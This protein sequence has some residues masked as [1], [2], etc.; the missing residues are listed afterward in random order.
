[1]TV[2]I[3]KTSLSIPEFLR[4]ARIADDKTLCSF[5]IPRCVM[6]QSLTYF[7]HRQAASIN[8]PN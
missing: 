3:I 2:A 5:C 6:S 1:M 7:V 8:F 4:S